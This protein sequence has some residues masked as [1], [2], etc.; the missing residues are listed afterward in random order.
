M[1][2][3]NFL[4][5][6]LWIFGID[7]EVQNLLGSEIYGTYAALLSLSMILNAL[8]D[9]GLTNYNTLNIS[10]N[11]QLLSKFF[12]HILGI[13]IILGVFYLAVMLVLALLFNYNSFQLKL[14]IWLAFNQFLVSLTLYFRSNIAA[15][16][17]F[18]TDSIL[19]VVDKFSM[20]LICGVLLYGSFSSQFSIETFLLAQTLGYLIAVFAA[21]FIVLKNLPVLKLKLNFIF[22]QS[23]LKKSF[24]YA[25]LAIL[26]YAYSRSDSVMMERMLPDGAYQ[27]GI[28]AQ[29]YRLL[30]ATNFVGF[31]FAGLLFPIFSKMLKEKQDYSSLLQLSVNLIIAFSVITASAFAFYADNWINLM[32]DSVDVDSPFIFK[33]VITCLVPLSVTYIFGTFLTASENIKRLNWIAFFGA[34]F[35]IVLNYFFIQQFSAKGA[36]FS[37]LITQFLVCLTHIVM[38]H[39]IFK[40]P[41][42]KTETFR[43]LTFIGM[44]L[45]IGFISKM[46]SENW[47]INCFALIVFSL[48][49]A[50]ITKL[51]NW[52]AALNI[53]KTKFS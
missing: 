49:S 28:Y 1:L 45:V 48:L 19:G 4:V 21:F 30:D 6:P 8:L 33:I 52:K 12:S 16:Q 37:Q 13:K 9:I 38:V 22:L 42:Q 2:L 34:I 47:M 35:N 17:Q 50:L 36:A 40:I 26:M 7:R 20:L 41:F 51:L 14:L 18:T 5:K 3:L 23:T 53:L 46:I 15:L 11:E 25:L 10:K 31:L 27:S 44:I 43:I 39:Q 24:P 32:Y 29:S